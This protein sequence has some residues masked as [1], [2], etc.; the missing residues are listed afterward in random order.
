MEGRN[1]SYNNNFNLLRLFAALQVFII[2]ASTH[3]DIDIGVL[4]QILGH[5]PGV[6][7][8]FT[9][10]GFLIMMSYDRNKSVKR[11]FYNRFLRIYP[12]LWVCSIFTIITLLIFRAISFRQLFTKDIISWFF[13]EI[14]VFQYYTPDI[15]RP[16]GVSAPNGSLWTI[17]VEIEFYILIPLV[18]LIIKKMPIGFKLISLFI[19]SYLINRLISPFVGSPNETILIKLIKS[20]L[21]PHLFNFIIGSVL[22]YLWDRIKKY[23][24]NKALF[25]VLSY[26]CYI[27]IFEF[28]LKLSNPSYY[29][30]IFGLISTV[31]LSIMTLSLAFTKQRLT[32]K[33]L[34]EN[35]ISYGI[36]I[37]HMP[38]KNIFLHIKRL[39]VFLPP[40]PPPALLK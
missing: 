33:I 21:F 13:A 16:W 17:P 14:T 30:N 36:Y 29:P 12:A 24:E 23:I 1:I 38:V 2:H 19:L 26:V 8:F 18:F 25:W 3:F 7:V 11:Y 31:L 35:D 9:I 10:S 20:S 15:L 5:F 32:F 6:P 39:I 4:E 27:V 40:P 22:Y 37:Y 34:K 28:I